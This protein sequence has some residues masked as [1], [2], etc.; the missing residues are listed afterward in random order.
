MEGT[1]C[2]A[3]SGNLFDISAHAQPCNAIAFFTSYWLLCTNCSV[4]I[5]LYNAWPWSATRDL[6]CH[7]HPALDQGLEIFGCSKS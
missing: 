3:R 1:F 6:H 4:G 7:Q 2:I 5:P